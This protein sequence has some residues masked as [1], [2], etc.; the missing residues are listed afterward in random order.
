VAPIV[1]V[2]VGH[3]QNNRG[4]SGSQHVVSSVDGANEWEVEEDVLVNMGESR[5][6]GDLVA[7]IIMSG[8]MQSMMASCKKGG[9]CRGYR[10]SLWRG[11]DNNVL[12]R[13]CRVLYQLRRE[14]TEIV[15]RRH[16]LFWKMTKG[17][18][19]NVLGGI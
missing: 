12:A 4:S 10:L 17:V 15:I 1:V 6:K 13:S 3:N 18:T 16:E 8:L 5:G 19:L 9:C 14:I 11:C 2:K 7:I